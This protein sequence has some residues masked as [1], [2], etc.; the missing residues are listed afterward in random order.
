MEEICRYCWLNVDTG[1]QNVIRPCACRN[2]LHINCLETFLQSYHR[3]LKCEVCNTSYKFSD[4]ITTE[5]DWSTIS[6]SWWFLFKTITVF[7]LPILR[8]IIFGMPY[9]LPALNT[10]VNWI[11]ILF[12]GITF[13]GLINYLIHLSYLVYTIIIVFF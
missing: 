9:K 8:E 10:T 11:D 1:D 5:F 12:L 6:Q 4:V 3:Q 7:F 13:F 2:Y